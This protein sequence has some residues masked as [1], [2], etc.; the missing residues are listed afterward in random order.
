MSSYADPIWLEGQRKRWTR[1]DAYRFAPPGSPEAK[2]PG[3]LDPWATRVRTKEAARDEA[4]ARAAAEQEEFEREVAELRDA[5]ARV[6]IMLADVKFELAL[7]AL[8]RKYSQ[9]QPR[10]PAGSPDG[11]QWTSGGG[12]AQSTDISAARKA[13][14]VR[15]FGKWTARQ[16]ISRYCKGSINREMPGEFENATIAEIYD[17]AKGGDARARA[18]LKLLKQDRFRK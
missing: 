2:M 1:P 12:D 6:R 3:W 9:D 17:I 18:C 4:R 16:F 7:R 13:D 14:I 11:G 15:Q 10:V 5:N 8:G